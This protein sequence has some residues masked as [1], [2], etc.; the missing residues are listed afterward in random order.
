MGLCA[1]APAH[2]ELEKVS[3]SA[4]GRYITTIFPMLDPKDDELDDGADYHVAMWFACR[5]DVL[6]SDAGVE[7][8]QFAR[9]SA[10]PWRAA[11]A[12]SWTTGRCGV[13]TTSRSLTS[14]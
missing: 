13:T 7:A 12:S 8:N 4:A 11:P 5:R 14:S 9:P 3:K 2:K 1:C 10:V 6:D